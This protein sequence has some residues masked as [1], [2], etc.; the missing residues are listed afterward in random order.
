MPRENRLVA[1]VNI[2]RILETVLDGR[3]RVH[4][5][6]SASKDVLPWIATSFQFLKRRQKSGLLC[7]VGSKFQ[8][9]FYG[10]TETFA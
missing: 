8:K 3:V 9:E 10:L 4:C 7:N 2:L 1:E 6:Y 5:Q